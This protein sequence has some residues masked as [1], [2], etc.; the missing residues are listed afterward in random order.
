MNRP[1]FARKLH[2]YSHIFQPFVIIMIFFTLFS[3]I[4]IFLYN[5][6]KKNYRPRVDYPQ[7]AYFSVVFVPLFLFT[8]Y[9]P[10]KSSSYLT[11]L[12]LQLQ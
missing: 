10:S 4:F 3:H 7:P 2:N 9:I 5:L 8:G 11:A 12:I 1:S 6:S